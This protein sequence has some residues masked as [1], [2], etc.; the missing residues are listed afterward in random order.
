MKSILSIPLETALRILGYLSFVDVC[1]ISMVS[2][3]SRQL[4]LHVLF[5]AVTLSRNTRVVMD[6]LLEEHGGIKS[7]IRHLKIAEPY[8]ASVGGQ[9][10]TSQILQLVRR[11]DNLVS[12]SLCRAGFVDLKDIPNLNESLKQTSV[13]ELSLH[14]S[15]GTSAAAVYGPSGLRR[16]QLQWAVGDGPSS[17]AH[18]IQF[19]TPS[20]PTLVELDI[21][22]CRWELFFNFRDQQQPVYPGMRSFKS[23]TNG[24]DTAELRAYAKM[25]PNLVTF[26]FSFMSI[27][28]NRVQW[29]V[30]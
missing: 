3:E 7:S 20:L 28:P 1:S 22:G 23:R 30:S 2:R 29:A 27:E 15:S 11:L 14:V 25:F 12:L 8:W 18:L 10:P 4:S 26:D 13:E 6:G 19:L 9:N 16:I 17:H 21:T 5:R 24:R